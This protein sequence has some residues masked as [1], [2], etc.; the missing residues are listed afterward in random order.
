MRCL[1][2]ADLHYS[3]P[4]FDWLLTAAPQFDLVIFA[5]DALDVGS[6]VD[7]RAPRSSYADDEAKE[8]DV[9]YLILLWGDAAG[10]A[11]LAPGERRRIVDEHLE[12]SAR[13]RERGQLVTGEPLEHGGKVVRGDLVTDGPFVETKERLGGFY[14]VDVESEDEA[15]AIA[16]EMPASPGL[17]ADVRRVPAT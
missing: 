17:V 3:L 5:G 10:E 6:R 13:L 2:V 1:V 16:R 14:L 7:F 8:D 9:R 11:E 4:Q 15:V 12:L